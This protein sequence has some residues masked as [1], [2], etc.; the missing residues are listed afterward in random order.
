MARKLNRCPSND[1][2]RDGTFVGQVSAIGDPREGFEIR[3]IYVIVDSVER[4]IERVGLRVA[5][6][7]HD[8]PAEKIAAR[9]GRSLDQ[10]SWF[11]AHSDYAILYDN[12]SSSPRVMVELKNGE[13]TVS[14]STM[15]EI[16]EALALDGYE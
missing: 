5:K 14:R 2:G 8:V 6:G 12:S 15:P 3:L 11:F 13:I 16:L 4:Q 1:R 7:G 10:L 9:R